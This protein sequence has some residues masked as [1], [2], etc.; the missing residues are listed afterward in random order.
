MKMQTLDFLIKIVNNKTT[1]LSSIH[2]SHSDQKKSSGWY[3]I[4]YKYMRT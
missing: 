4:S 2:S 3:Y 1:S